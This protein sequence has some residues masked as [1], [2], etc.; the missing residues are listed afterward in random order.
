MSKVNYD[1]TK[2]DIMPYKKKSKR[3]RIKKSTHKHNYELV[4]VYEPKYIFG[5]PYYL[6]NFCLTC[7]K[8]E[9]TKHFFS[10]MCRY[11]LKEDYLKDY[12]NIRIVEKIEDS[13]VFIE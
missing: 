9:M 7:G 12:P 8:L 6:A 3:K 4:L 2:D 13:V 10:D 11:K 5:S 1:Y